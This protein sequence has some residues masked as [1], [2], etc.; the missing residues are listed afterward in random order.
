[1]LAQTSDP[2]HS[3]LKTLHRLAG[4]TLIVFVSLHL[5]NHLMSLGG[6]ETHLVFM[7]TL[8]S[9]YR[10]WLAESVLLLAVGVQLFSGFG[11]LRQKSRTP[12][13]GFAKIQRW[14]GAYLAFFLSIHLAAIF[15]GRYLLQLDTNFY[16]G[17]AGLNA[18]PA[19]LFFVPY[20]G[21]AVLAFFG[22]L[23]GIHY[24]KMPYRVMGMNVKTQ[25]RLILLLG[26]L[27]SFGILLGFTHG[28]SGQPIPSGYQLFHLPNAF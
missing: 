25:A 2:H 13:H 28:F 6:V 20:Y 4:M 5:L 18:F 14:S 7:E 27:C 26:F 8:R 9:Y 3:P 11:L 15:V 23:A 10:H 1:M 12:S 19:L 21:L 17:A 24:H 22:H 16:F